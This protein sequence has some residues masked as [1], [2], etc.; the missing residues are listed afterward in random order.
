VIPLS[1]LAFPKNSTMSDQDDLDYEPEVP[2]VPTPV[3]GALIPNVPHTQYQYWPCPNRLN[4]PDLSHVGIPTT[5]N[6]G[7]SKSPPAPIASMDLIYPTK[8]FLLLP[9]PPECLPVPVLHMLRTSTGRHKKMPV[10]VLAR[11]AKEK[12]PVWAPKV[13]A[14]TRQCPYWYWHDWQKKN[15]SMGTK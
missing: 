3:A 7:L 5:T 13:L 4:G 10:L 12:I 11:L 1:V 6:R 9:P 2:E 8:E 14:D 15:P